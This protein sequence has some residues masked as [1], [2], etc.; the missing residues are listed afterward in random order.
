MTDSGP[1]FREES[2]GM[3]LV[4]RQRLVS[5]IMPFFLSRC[6]LNMRFYDDSGPVFQEE[7]NG[8]R[9]VAR[10]RLVSEIMPFFLSRCS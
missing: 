1:V 4:A 6:S 3:R 2:N 7:S 10:Q 8:M 9:L 5:E